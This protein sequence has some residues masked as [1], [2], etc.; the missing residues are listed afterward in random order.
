ML[1]NLIVHANAYFLFYITNTFTAR[2]SNHKINLTYSS[3]LF[4]RFQEP[5][6]KN[7]I[8]QNWKQAFL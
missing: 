6:L 3:F 5:Y 2:F 4:S 7:N 8:S 1:Q